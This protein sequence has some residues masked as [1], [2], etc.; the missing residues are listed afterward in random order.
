[1]FN[2]THLFF[3]F[4]HFILID[5]FFTHFQELLPQ[6]YLQHLPFVFQLNSDYLRHVQTLR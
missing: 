5:L 1:M 3:L 6:F 4:L 2:L